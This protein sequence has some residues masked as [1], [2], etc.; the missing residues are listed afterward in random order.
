[1]SIRIGFCLLAGIG[2]SVSYSH[3]KAEAQEKPKPPNVVLILADD[4]GF[5]D[6]GCYGHPSAKT[7]HLDKLASQG[8]KFTQYY[9]NG[10]ECTPTRTAFLTG[11]YQQ[12]VGGMECAIGVGNVGRYDDAI[13]LAEQGELGLPKEQAV[14]PGALKKAGYTCGIFGKWHL[15][16]EPHFNPIEHGWD[17]FTGYLGGNVHYFTHRE[18]S[19]LHVYFRD[20]LPV[21]REGYMTHLITEDSV[22]FI[23]KHKSE[24][25]FLYI[26]HECPHLPHQGPMDQEKLV[27]EDNWNKSDKATYIAMLDDLDREVGRVVDAIDKAGLANNTLI[28][29]ASDNGG[30]KP[31][32]HLAGL[33]GAKGTT[34]EG[35]I[36]V[37][38]IIR[39]P[40]KIKPGTAS[41]QVCTTFDV[42]A[43]FLAIAQAE[44]RSL[45]LDGIDIIS[46]ISEGAANVPRTLYW[47]GKRGNETWWAVRDGDYKFVRTMQGQKS[48]EWLFDVKS[49]PA[50][51]KDL[52][53]EQS[54]MAD[55]LKQ[56]LARWEIG[57]KAVR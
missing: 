12:R 34:F 51:Q 50:E 29:F 27:N 54:N 40:G 53:S 9:S 30:I 45:K 38:L 56:K 15:G 31:V 33:N 47:R 21:Y 52:K 2:I 19:D 1:M 10:P 41:T 3:L 24:P 48:E 26:A 55:Q 20:R 11:R 35:G 6:L 32:S 5:G 4:L 42:T 8:V 17:E 28:A 44:T 46:R 23:E 57:V 25:F 7:P 43:S 18:T 14:L 16:Y 36:R 39:W 22:A 13:R 37:P 49:D